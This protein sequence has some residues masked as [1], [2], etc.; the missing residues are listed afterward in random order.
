MPTHGSASTLANVAVLTCN[1]FAAIIVISLNKRAFKHFPYP[2]ALTSLHYFV[3]W[4]GVTIL[5]WAGVFAAQPVPAEQSR[6]FWW[7]V[8]F[9]SLGNALSN[10]SLDRNSVGFYQLTKLMI[11]PSIVAFDAFVYSRRATPP[12][13]L[14]LVLSC[15]GVGLVSVNDVQFH[16]LGAMFATGATFAAG[17][18]KVLNSHVQQ[19][20]GL[21]SLQVMH[22]AFPA[23]SLLSL[24]YVPLL[25]RKL[26]RLL[27][28]EWLDDGEAWLWMASSA[29]A[30][31]CATWSATAIFGRIS[32]LAHVLL[33]QVKTCSV[34]LVGWLVY[35]AEQTAG[36]LGGAALALTS[37]TVYSLSKLPSMS[38][39]AEGVQQRREVDSQQHSLMSAGEVDSAES[40]EEKGGTGGRR[41]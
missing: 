2:A 24:M 13:A 4:A 33:G 20:G 15:L 14:A 30:A 6:T 17:A 27:E 7:L 39:G 18:Q 34:L 31:F 21:T 9:W 29:L 32:A 41:W 5:N 36:G 25:D 10:V 26:H 23:M 3:S 35:D 22:N 37:I 12:Q 19:I 8:L 28:F 11:T 1:F 40:E 38:G 16:A